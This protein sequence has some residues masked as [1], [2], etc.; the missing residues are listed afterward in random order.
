[1]EKRTG[2]L[3]RRDFMK[4][5]AAGTLGLAAGGLLAG[6]QSTQ[7]ASSEAKTSSA[8]EEKTTQSQKET[9]AAVVETTTY[10]CDVVLVGAGG[11]GMLGAITALKAGKKVIVIEKA[12][13]CDMCN[14][15]IVSGS[16]AIGTRLQKE[17]GNTVTVE[18]VFDHMQ[19]FGQGTINQPLLRA[20]LE[21][22][23]ISLDTWEE[24]GMELKMADDR[25]GVGFVTVHILSDRYS[26]M[27]MLEAKILE[28]GG[29]VIYDAA[30]EEVIM[31]ENVCKGVR[32]TFGDGTPFEVHAK[33]AILATGGFLFNQE[34]M[35]RHFGK[36]NK[37]ALL[38]SEL[39]TGDGIS[40]AL[41]TGQ[42]I[43]GIRHL[44]L[45]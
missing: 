11:A 8:A 33:A 35:E 6:C 24:C 36:A 1:M 39:T 7:P 12:G 18:E 29:E 4:G 20:A 5:M 37:I 23:K 15:S 9:T 34:M 41:N 44:S 10:N 22:T 45:H 27:A 40:A 43:H 16:T 13:G 2:N 26:R 30:M 19:T 31:E 28:L 32:G 3:S 17:V 21:R 38:G 14:S 25:Y 42:R